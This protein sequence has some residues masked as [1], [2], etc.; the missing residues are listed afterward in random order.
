MVIVLITGGDRKQK[1]STLPFLEKPE[2]LR[3]IAPRERHMLSF[4]SLGSKD[5]KLGNL[6]IF[7]TNFW[8][9]VSS[10]KLVIMTHLKMGS[11]GKK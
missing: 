8:F 9:G 11:Q 5:F 10:C 7:C 3:T 1:K 2:N 4:S 6:K